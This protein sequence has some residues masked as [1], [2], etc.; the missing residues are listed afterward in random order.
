MNLYS[1]EMS[2]YLEKHLRQKLNPT[3]LSD[4]NKANFMQKSLFPVHLA[5]ETNN[6][7]TLKNLT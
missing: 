3:N 4:T 6:Y 5:D 7:N 1:T 2:F